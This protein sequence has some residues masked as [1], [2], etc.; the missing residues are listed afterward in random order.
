MALIFHI[1]ER[2]AWDAARPAGSYRPEAFASE[3]FIHC[4]TR[5]QVVRVADA[6]FRNQHG[7]V[8]LCIDAERVA[9]EIVYENLEGGRELF[10][11]IY[12]GLDAGA[13]VDVLEF[14]P[15]ADGRFAF[16]ENFTRA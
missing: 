1:T 15:G 4:S 12:G 2:A 13:V 8:L 7:L 9:A 5:E 10:P 14:E 16:P 3:G 11:H 6:R